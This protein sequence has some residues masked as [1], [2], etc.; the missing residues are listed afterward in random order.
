MHYLAILLAMPLAGVLATGSN[1]NNKVHKALKSVEKNTRVCEY[2][3]ET[4]EKWESTGSKSYLPVELKKFEPKD[5]LEACDCLGEDD[6]VEAPHFKPS[7]KEREEPKV[8]TVTKTV[9]KTVPKTTTE[10]EREVETQT[11]TETEMVTVSETIYKPRTYTATTTE[12]DT[13]IKC[14]ATKTEAIETTTT[15]VGVVTETIAATKTEFKTETDYKTE[16]KTETATKTEYVKVPAKCRPTKVSK[17]TC[18]DDKEEKKEEKEE[19]PKEEDPIK[20]NIVLDEG[21]KHEEHHIIGKPGQKHFHKPG[22]KPG[23][24]PGQKKPVQKLTH[25]NKL[26][27]ISPNQPCRLERQKDCCSGKCGA[28]RGVKAGHGKCF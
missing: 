12:T 26:Q 18:Q 3:H 2:L 7:P 22:Q 5:V 8:K 15:T 20:I 28:I 9:T 10:I 1:C 17:H 21:V 27:C 4:Q 14:T 6:Y 24:K 16:F 11:T 25:D 23:K 13:V 19:K